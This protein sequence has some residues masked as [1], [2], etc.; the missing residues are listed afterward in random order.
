MTE[1]GVREARAAGTAGGQPVNGCETRKGRGV[2]R[3]KDGGEPFRCP[4]CGGDRET[5]MD[6]GK[7]GG[8]E[9]TIVLCA[10]GRGT[11]ARGSAS[12]WPQ[13]EGMGGRRAAQ[14]GQSA[15]LEAWTQQQGRALRSSKTT[16]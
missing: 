11:R 8:G 1:G 14:R 3:D 2:L 13:A 4:D 6:T 10:N 7:L 5:S 9:F 16:G 12:Q 15:N